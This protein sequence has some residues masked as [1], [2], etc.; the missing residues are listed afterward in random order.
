MM[1]KDMFICEFPKKRF[2]FYSK[3]RYISFIISISSFGQHGFGMLVQASYAC[4]FLNF[5]PENL[6]LAPSSSSIRKIWLYL[7]N[8]SDR[9]GAPVLICPVERPT[10]K[11]AMKQSSVSP[12]LCETMVPHPF[13]FANK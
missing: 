13:F 9:Q 11:S 6:A 4:G 3:C 1:W 7:H 12:D 10:T 2:K 5:S 8:L